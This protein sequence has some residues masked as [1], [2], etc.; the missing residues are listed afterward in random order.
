MRDFFNSMN[1]IRAISPVVVSDNTAEVG[2]II[3]RQG[4]DGLRP[5]P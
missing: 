4:F 5:S 3:D 1:P 2:Q